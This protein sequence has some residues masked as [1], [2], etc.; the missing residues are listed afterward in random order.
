MRLGERTGVF[1]NENRNGALV[2]VSL[3]ACRRTGFTRLPTTT[4]PQSG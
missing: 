1:P 2:S 4:I 3:M